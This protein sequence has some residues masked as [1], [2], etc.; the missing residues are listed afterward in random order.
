[1]TDLEQAISE[2]TAFD[3]GDKFVSE[4]QVRDYFRVESMRLMFGECDQNQATLDEWAQAV[5]DNG[6][7]MEE[8]APFAPP[9][10]RGCGQV[11]GVEAYDAKL[12]ELHELRRDGRQHSEGLVFDSEWLQEN[13]LDEEDEQVLDLTMSK[14]MHQRGLCPTCGRPN[15]AGLGQGDF[16]DP[17]EARWAAEAHAE[18][19]AEFRA[20]CG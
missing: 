1:M 19:M 7:H 15:L 3:R 13:V 10:C 11:T 16:V 6:W 2:A 20:G 17:E 8:E 5:I 18:R 14:D 12:W 9:V 4:D